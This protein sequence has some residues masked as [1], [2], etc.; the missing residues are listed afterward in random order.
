MVYVDWSISMLNITEAQ[1]LIEEFIQLRKTA[2]ESPEDKIRFKN[3]ELL[4]IKKFKYLVTMK[5]SRYRSFA[6]YED[7]NQEGLAALVHSMTNYNPKLGN[8]FWWSHKYIDTR[9]SRCANLHTTIR[10][11]MKVAKEFPPHK[12]VAMPLMVAEDNP[13]D[14][15]LNIELKD[16]IFSVISLL[17]DSQKNIINLYFG[18]NTNSPMSVNKICKELK[19]SRSTC[20]KSIKKSLAFVKEN[21]SL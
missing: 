15:I 14:N 7:L 16:E 11:P 4:C 13:E 18:F 21:I 20:V 9:I 10:Y 5:T 3:H 6:N 12:E 8:F 17:D 1:K 2:N 19:I